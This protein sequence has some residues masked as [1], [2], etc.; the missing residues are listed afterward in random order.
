MKTRIMATLAAATLA[1]SMGVAIAGEIGGA[2]IMDGA[3]PGYLQQQQQLLRE[4]GYSI[5]TGAAHVSN[6][7]DPANDATQRALQ[8]IPGGLPV[9]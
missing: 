2:G 6:V 8:V 3:S 9:W 1:L 7:S 5:G 4:P